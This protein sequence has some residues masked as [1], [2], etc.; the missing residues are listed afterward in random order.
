MARDGFFTGLDIGTKILFPSVIVIVSKSS[1]ALLGVCWTVWI[2]D[3]IVL[4][5]P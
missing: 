5:I 2:S 1:V 3:L 4:E